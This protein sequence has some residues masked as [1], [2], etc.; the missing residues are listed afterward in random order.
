MTITL[1]I[2]WFD[3]HHDMSPNY[4]ERHIG[5]IR[6]STPNECMAKYHEFLRNH[7]LSKYTQTEIIAI[8]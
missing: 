4:D 5:R 2:Q 3:R 1:L 7:D 8:Y 6:G